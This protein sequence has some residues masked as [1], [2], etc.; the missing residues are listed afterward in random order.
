[1]KISLKDT[2]N[3]VVICGIA[4][5]IDPKFPTLTSVSLANRLQKDGAQATEWCYITFSN[6]KEG[7]EGR[8]MADFARE[9]I[10]K[11]SFVMALCYQKQNG[12]YTNYYANACNDENGMFWQI[13]N[14]DRYCVV[15]KVKS[16]SKKSDD[17]VEVVVTAK[18]HDY[19]ITFM[20]GEKPSQKF[21]NLTSYLKENQTIGLIVTKRQKDQYTNYYANALEFGPKPKE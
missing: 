20:N 9:N 12:E 16:I 1:M 14:S 4:G 17:I 15:G 5:Y 6:P 11:G 10:K 18:E 8:K 13:E 7:K 21:A 19:K 2:N 3:L